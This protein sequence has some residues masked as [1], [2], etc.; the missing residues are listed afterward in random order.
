MC[1]N[2]EKQKNSVLG[3]IKLVIKLNFIYLLGQVGE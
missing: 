1:L 3:L 2:F